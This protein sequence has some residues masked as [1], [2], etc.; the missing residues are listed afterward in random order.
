MLGNHD[1]N[2]IGK[3][4]L[5]NLNGEIIPVTQKY[6]LE[7]QAIINILKINPSAT[8]EEIA[9]QIGKSLRTVKTRMSE[10]KEKSFIEKANYFQI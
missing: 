9:E 3:F 4:N 10:M 7:E 8:Q 2:Y 5:K 6:T 1:H